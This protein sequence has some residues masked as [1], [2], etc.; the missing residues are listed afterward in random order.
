M[1]CC[2]PKLGVLEVDQAGVRTPL[3][4]VCLC[5]HCP[6]F[7]RRLPWVVWEPVLLRVAKCKEQQ[8]VVLT[9][10]LIG[11]VVFATTVD[12]SLPLEDV[13]Q[14]AIAAPEART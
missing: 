6:L 1:W 12:H 8:R 3:S 7:F 5:N 4:V 13:E 11:C 10:S 14:R 9:S 2:M